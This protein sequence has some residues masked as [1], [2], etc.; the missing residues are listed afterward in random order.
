MHGYNLAMETRDNHPEGPV[1]VGRVVVSSTDGPMLRRMLVVDW[2]SDGASA[3][4]P[5]PTACETNPDGYYSGSALS[6]GRDW[7]LCHYQGDGTDADHSSALPTSSLLYLG[8]AGADVSQVVE[9]SPS[10]NRFLRCG[11][12]RP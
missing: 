9:V 7:L 1:V 11:P 2:P 6:P 4:E 10:T 3:A 5:E 12:G 8:E